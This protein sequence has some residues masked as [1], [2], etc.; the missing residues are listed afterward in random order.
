[1]N[2]G[3]RP[4]LEPA[5]L[6]DTLFLV[7][8]KRDVDGS[9]SLACVLSCLGLV[10]WVSYL[11]PPHV[12]RQRCSSLGPKALSWAPPPDLQGPDLDATGT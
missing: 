8:C 7:T 11:P 5:G 9:L 1:M 4:T 6:G 2:K 3:G 12:C 10:F